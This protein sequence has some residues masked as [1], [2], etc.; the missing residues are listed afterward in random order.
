MRSRFATRC[1]AVVVEFRCIRYRPRFVAA[2]DVGVKVVTR[3][4]EQEGKS[5]FDT[6]TA[7]DIYPIDSPTRD[8][9]AALAVIKACNVD[10]RRTKYRT[11]IDKGIELDFDC[12]RDSAG[13]KARYGKLRTHIIDPLREKEYVEIDAVSSKSKYVSVTD[14]GI[15]ALRAFRHR[16]EDVI[17]ELESSPN[18]KVNLEFDDPIGEIERWNGN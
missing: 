14:A 7:L 16:V 11:I 2:I 13:G 8:Q 17:V 5:T 15:Q 9:L 12:F 4:S 3:S 10:S 6:G 18:P 1:V